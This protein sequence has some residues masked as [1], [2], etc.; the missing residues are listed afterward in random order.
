M[1]TKLIKNDSLQTLEVYLMTPEGI[2]SFLFKPHDAK[3]V[4]ASFLTEQSKKLQ[5]RRL[6]TITNA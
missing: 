4:P 2:K 6:I 5:K 1:E 3:V